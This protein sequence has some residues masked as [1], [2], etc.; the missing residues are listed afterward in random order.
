MSQAARIVTR[1]MWDELTA[2]R[3]RQELGEGVHRLWRLELVR[4][5]ARYIRL[6][7]KAEQ[8]GLAAALHP[9]PSMD[10]MLAAYTIVAFGSTELAHSF[11]TGDREAKDRLVAAVIADGGVETD[12]GYWMEAG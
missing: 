8:W 7:E 5:Y 9:E 6:R 3:E 4:I 2:A 10:W 11:L 12:V 1:R